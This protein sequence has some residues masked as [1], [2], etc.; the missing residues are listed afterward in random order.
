MQLQ[1]AKVSLNESKTWGSTLNMEFDLAVALLVLS[2][3]YVCS[4]TVVS[5]KHESVGTKFN[6]N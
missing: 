5:Y 2:H 4:Q 1:S 3:A 6:Y